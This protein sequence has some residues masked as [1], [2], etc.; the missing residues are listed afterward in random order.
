VRAAG[1]TGVALRDVNEIRPRLLPRDGDKM[2][3]EVGPQAWVELYAYAGGTVIAARLEGARGDDV[4]RALTAA[5]LTV[6]RRSG[7]I[8]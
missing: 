5:G 2:P 7:N 8:G 1:V 3:V 6:R 4:E